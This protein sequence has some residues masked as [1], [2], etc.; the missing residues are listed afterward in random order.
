[1]STREGERV[2][3]K[4]RSSPQKEEFS[5]FLASGWRGGPAGVQMKGIMEMRMETV[6]ARH[7]GDLCTGLICKW[8]D[9][10]EEGVINFTSWALDDKVSVSFQFFWQFFVHFEIEICVDYC[11]RKAR[12]C[13]KIF[14]E[15][16]PNVIVRILSQGD[17]IGMY[18]Y[19]WY[20]YWYSLKERQ[21][22][23]HTTGQ[24]GTLGNSAM[25]AVSLHIKIISRRNI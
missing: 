3:W 2:R 15:L 22:P 11:E 12:Q 7:T 24:I 17:Y 4:R 16:R 25:R 6:P 13:G 10:E 19:V 20:V 9:D 5:S 18:M 23:A 21:L 14:G 8:R 1:M